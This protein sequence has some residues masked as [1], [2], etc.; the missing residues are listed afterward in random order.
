MLRASVVALGA[1]DFAG[2]L[3]ALKRGSSPRYAIGR[4]RR[5]WVGWKNTL[6]VVSPAFAPVHDNLW[7]ER[8]VTFHIPAYVYFS[9][10]ALA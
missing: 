9:F 10:R 7:M 8:L 5:G 4:M 3:I 6:L 1:I 2:P